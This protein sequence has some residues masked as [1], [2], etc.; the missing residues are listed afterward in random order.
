MIAWAGLG[1]AV[2]GSEPE[3]LAAAD[4]TIPGPGNGGIKQLADVLIGAN[5]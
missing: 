5:A 1:V 4:W 3:V 2:Q